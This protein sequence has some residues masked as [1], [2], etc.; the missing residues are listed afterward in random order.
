M[1]G[2][3]LI[4]DRFAGA[5]I[6]VAEAALQA[7]HADLVA[8]RETF[9]V[10]VQGRLQGTVVDAALRARD[11][12]VQQAHRDGRRTV[13]R[14]RGQAVVAQFIADQG[15]AARVH[16]LAAA[17]VLVEEGGAAAGADVVARHQIAQHET[18]AVVTECAV[19]DLAVAADAHRQRAR[20]D[21]EGRRAAQGDVVLG[22][23]QARRRIAAHVARIAAVAEA[24]IDARVAIKQS[25]IADRAEEGGQLAIVDLTCGVARQ[26][27]LQRLQES[28]Q[29]RRRIAF[30]D[31]PH[32]AEIVVV[33]A[34]LLPHLRRTEAGG[35][36]ATGL[37]QRRFIIEKTIAERGAGGHAAGHRAHVRIAVASHGAA[38][39]DMA[40]AAR[41]FTDQSAHVFPGQDGIGGGGPAHG[42]AGVRI[43]DA[44]AVQAHQAADAARAADIAGGIRLAQRALVVADQAADHF[45][46]A[47]HH[48]GGIRSRDAGAGRIRSR[49]AADGAAAIGIDAGDGAAAAGQRDG[50]AVAAHKAADIALAADGHAAVH[51]LDSAADHI[52]SQ[53]AH[54]RRA[55]DAAAAQ[56]QVAQGAALHG[57]KQACRRTWHLAAVDHQIAERK[58][59]AIEHAGKTAAAA[60]RHEA[61]AIVPVHGAAGVEIAGQ[62][63][64]VA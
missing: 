18:G 40:D 24:A 28:L 55:G 48:A 57:T 38:A 61:L 53:R 15:Q 62:A 1:A 6:L 4:I 63:I 27:H 31:A 12:I 2:R 54:V 52:A 50:A 20:R 44:A 42:A 17:H 3:Y 14:R 41:A 16:G 23:P 32:A 11:A 39:E 59:A 47:R 33:E 29:H 9:E 7:F 56:D 19:I 51:V 8:R 25:H 35:A 45:T 36:A 21:G 43:V 10:A 58:S 46:R 26:V 37:H 22:R 34:G 49:Q 64:V 13:R 60:N 5:D 30:V